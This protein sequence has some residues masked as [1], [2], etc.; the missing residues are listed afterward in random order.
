MRIS[1]RYILFVVFDC[2]FASGVYAD[3]TPSTLLWDNHPAQAWHEGYA[4]GNGH[5]GAV[6]Y[7]PMFSETVVLND[8]TIWSRAANNPQPKE[9]AKGL[10]KVRKACRSGNVIEAGRLYDS[11]VLIECEAANPYQVLGLLNVQHLDPAGAPLKEAPL[12]YRRDLDLVT[13]M[14]RSR[15]ALDDGMILH[16]VLASQPDQCVLLRLSSTRP[17]GL[18]VRLSLVNPLKATEVEAVGDTLRIIGQADGG[19]TRFVGLLRVLATDGEVDVTGNSLVVKGAIA[20]IRLTAATDYNHEDPQA[21]LAEGWAE[22][23]AALQAS[24]AE[25]SWTQLVDRATEDHARLMERCSVDIGT[26]SPEQLGWPMSKRVKAVRAGGYDPDL[27]ETL[28][29]LGRHLLVSSSRPGTLP[30]NL[31][32][33]WNPSPKPPWKAD[34]HLNINLQMNYW[35]AEV[36]GLTECHEPCL[37][38]LE[39]MK[40][41]AEVM[42]RN[43]GHAG[44]SAGLATDGWAR[45][46][47]IG[48]KS[49]WAGWVFGY[50]WTAEHLM[51]HYRFT[52]DREFLAQRAWPL[53]RGNSEFL[54]SWLEVD[55]ETGELITGPA[56]SPENTFFVKDKKGKRK[57]LCISMGSTCDQMIAWEGLNDLVACAE[58]L[59]K[60]DDPVVEKAREALPRLRGP[61]IGA[62]GRI[63]EWRKPFAEAEK[64]H[65]HMSHLYGFC[66]G[67]QIT[68]LND[69][70][71][72]AAVRRS[73]ETR[74]KKGGGHTG[75][76]MAWVINLWARLHDGDQALQH[77]QRFIKEH[78]AGNLFNLHES[79]CK[80]PFQIEG[81]FGVTAGLAEMLVQ[82][83]AQAADGRQILHILPALPA[84]WQTGQAAGLRARG[85]LV[86]EDLQ[87]EGGVCTGLSL[88]A[89]KE[90]AF[91]LKIQ[92]APVVEQRM[93][94]GQ[95]LRVL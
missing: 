72:S 80:L 49:L 8:D 3:S 92:G 95:V 65:R 24:L 87:W 23:A 90:V 2:A 11:E 19:G 31:Q 75:W 46:R 29:Q 54:L 41:Q 71:L 88:K 30:A 28:F 38:L 67:R 47:V 20:E 93:E 12:K 36:T 56:T 22:K 39:K 57:K 51:E 16:E 77:V 68:M 85:G 45:A 81:N 55:R 62:D 70:E 78:A 63:M 59:G 35:P 37:W 53:L 79:K 76:S 66:P 48:G 86:V 1:I 13:G 58:L 43:L 26:S 52:G 40:P 60:Q 21:P 84:K 34:Y 69:P 82:S 94:A 5:L 73:L 10:Q 33:L 74:L 50:A 42:A 9:A 91:Q 83:H 25:S 7:G 18:H 15:A 17:Q 4:V 64:R 32:G 6:Q 14:A 27:I 44:L 61:K 89:V